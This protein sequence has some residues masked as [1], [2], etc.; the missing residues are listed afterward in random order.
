MNDSREPSVPPRIGALAD[1]QSD[2]RD[3]LARVLHDQRV[4]IDHLAHVAVRL[5][6]LHLE[7]GARHAGHHLRAPATASQASF[8]FR[9]AVTKSRTSS[10]TEV[11]STP[12]WTT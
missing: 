9:P 8:S 3:R 11:R 10:L 6:D 7:R 12:A 2:A 4:L 5:L 1:A